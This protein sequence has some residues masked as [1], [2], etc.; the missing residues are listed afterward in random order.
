MGLSSLGEQSMR[1][2]VSDAF[3]TRIAVLPIDSLDVL[4]A[5]ALT[6]RWRAW[7]AA[8]ERLQVEA[9]RL[10]DTLREMVP[11]APDRA[12]R[13]ALIELRRD[14]HNL[15][16]PK[17]HVL[18]CATR[19]CRRELAAALDDFINAC[20][21][22]ARLENET[23][24][25][26]ER[27]LTA[28]K[29]KLRDLA[30]NEAFMRGLQ[31]AS[32]SLFDGSRRYIRDQ[33][34]SGSRADRIERGLLRYLSRAAAKATPF[35]S[36]CVIAEGRF[37]E[38]GYDGE[39]VY[40][41]LTAEPQVA[42][43]GVRLNKT[44]YGAIWETLR[45]RPGVRDRITVTVNGT[46]TRDDMAIRFLA[47]S[48]GAEAFRSLRRSPALDVL[49]DEASAA[50]RTAFSDLAR[51][52]H[53]S[54][55]LSAEP[56]DIR[57]Y[58]D[59]LIDLGVLTGSEPVHEQEP[60]WAEE[61][62]RE[63]A[64]L[65]DDETVEEIRR[66]L[67]ALAHARQEFA[68]GDLGARHVHLGNARTA[69][70]K[71]SEVTSKSFA[72]GLINPFYEDVA[73]DVVFQIPRTA[74]LSA[75]L[76]EFASFAEIT[77]PLGWPNADQMRMREFFHRRYGTAVSAVP[78]LQFYEDYYRDKLAR[79]A[80]PANGSAGDKPVPPPLGGGTRP[81][82]PPE[83]IRAGFARLGHCLAPAWA[84]APGARA[85]SVPLSEIR[86]AIRLSAPVP[87]DM[88]VAAFVNLVQAQGADSRLQ[89]VLPFGRYHAGFGKYYSRFLHLLP[90]L[91]EHVLRENCGHTC[92]LLSEIA[93]DE[94]F[95]A[96]L[97]PPMLP[98]QLTY[99][100]KNSH[101][102]AN[103]L[104]WRDIVVSCDRESGGTL[105]LR[106]CSDGHVI[107]A[108]DVGFLNTQMRPPLFRMLMAFTSARAFQVH[109]PDAPAGAGTPPEHVRRRPR[110]II[111]NHLIIGRETWLVPSAEMPRPERAESDSSFFR[112]V[113]LWRDQHEIP[114]QVFVRVK[115][116]S[117]RSDIT[118][119]AVASARPDQDPS[120]GILR[121]RTL[122]SED[123]AKQLA[124]QDAGR[125]GRAAPDWKKPAYI[126][127]TAPLMVKMFATLPGQLSHFV[128]EV[129]EC[130]PTRRDLVYHPA[131]GRYATEVVL[132]WHASAD[133]GVGRMTPADRG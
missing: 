34:A 49:W 95:N 5:P 74:D 25:L 81:E 4:G 117:P 56:D 128:L 106:R 122:A 64:D 51:V 125:L 10:S 9:A 123:A 65:R 27:S 12:H 76:D 17:G 37:R 97:H 2:H 69:V 115:P 127:F 11:T 107:R 99:P 90:N 42:A 54:G 44:L 28:S 108:I 92:A 19:H 103:Q 60:N 102:A 119:E 20:E 23:H 89:I 35:G 75:V 43:R 30:D 109:L 118:S 111:G 88:S 14:V 86:D 16:R 133:E 50:G 93:G 46:A 72:T 48:G 15:R 62:L 3:L 32:A 21:A 104:D 129:E 85:V 63:M 77:A 7:R 84:K 33:V 6:D 70:A 101:D 91:A 94:G 130:L 98:W 59:R 68:S 112:R 57:N 38:H 13:N 87:P 53:D 78:V 73:T 66:A 121:A 1:L 26:Y 114:D 22:A 18:E 39:G 71:L 31:L 131:T 105:S 55:R 67:T 82:L 79:S 100:G 110:L 29:A 61:L 80:D 36:F 40:H 124:Q 41:P 83:P 96:N 113:T 45:R 132:Q 8:R 58:L 47:T 116:V 52:I 24:C 120:D 126:D